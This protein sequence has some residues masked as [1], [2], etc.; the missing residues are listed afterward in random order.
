MRGYF[1]LKK[2]CLFLLFSNIAVYLYAAQLVVLNT[3]DLHGRAVNRYGGIVQIA[4]LI[5]KQ[6]KL[7]HP[8]SMLLIDCGDT[9]QGTFT[10]MFFQGK[11]MI[12]CL[13]YLKYDVWV[14]G[15]HEFDYPEKAVKKCMRQFSGVTLAANLQSSYLAEN[16]SSWKMFTKNGIKVAV[17]GLT[18]S[19]RPKT[20]PFA[21]ALNRIMP[22]IR[23]K[24]PDI[25][26]LAQHEGMYARGFSIYKFMTQYPEIDLVLGGHTHV[27]KPGQKIGANTWYFQSGKHAAGLGKIIIDYDLKKKKIIKINSEIIPVTEKTPAD[28]KLLALIQPDLKQ[29]KKYG[30]QKVTTMIFKNTEKLDSS[31]LEQKIIGGAML[32]Q[33]G[34]DVA[35]GNT[36]PSNYKLGGKVEI[37][38]KRLYYWCRYDNTT[39]TLNLDKATY[40]EIMTEQKKWAKK[41]Y[42]TIITY[43]DENSFNKKNKIVA[44]FNSYAISGGGGRFPFLRKTA[45]NKKYMLK[46]NNI[47]IRDSLRNYLKG[48]LFT[49]TN[50][51][52]KITIKQK[53]SV[54][55]AY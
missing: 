52:G 26:I 46:N 51:D 48:K 24:K 50:K 17:I 7:Y 39:C 55:S 5:D 33:T 1:M 42:S 45:R 3:T 44:A 40:R 20:T 2:L 9:I 49:V 37:N 14:V 30:D 8:D 28:K 47:L 43:A 53:A 18:K 11:L 31:I 23:A 25:I 54:A 36:Y 16:Y 10:S 29:A 13:N 41:N 32:K 15:N 21:A 19:G 12:K 34:A 6:K 35:V 27:K 22:E 38:L 4:Y